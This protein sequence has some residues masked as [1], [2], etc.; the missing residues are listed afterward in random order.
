MLSCQNSGAKKGATVD[1]QVSQPGVWT[2]RLAPRLLWGSATIKYWG[3]RM[4][5][6]RNVGLDLP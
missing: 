2:Q 3:L 4:R 6:H 5:P 1:R